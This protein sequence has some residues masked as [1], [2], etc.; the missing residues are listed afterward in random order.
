MQV[1]QLGI[2]TVTLLVFECAGFIYSPTDLRAATYKWNT[3]NLFLKMRHVS[4]IDCDRAI[5]RYSCDTLCA[6]KSYW[7]IHFGVAL[8]DLPL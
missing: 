1:R 7:S 5:I 6:M 3:A 8:S 4:I 2:C